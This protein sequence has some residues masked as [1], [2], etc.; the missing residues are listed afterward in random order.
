MRKRL[1][2]GGIPKLTKPGI[3]GD[4]GRGSFGLQLRVH[5][6]KTG[7]TTRSFRQAIRVGG[8]LTNL[9]LGSWP[10][11]SLEGA[12]TRCLEN[13]VAVRRGIDPRTRSKAVRNDP[14]PSVAIP[15]A[16]PVPATVP[17]F[18]A[19]FEKVIDAARPNWKNGGSE[20][21]RRNALDGLPF[22]DARVDAVTSA[23]IV[24]A[25]TPVWTRT[26]TVADWRARVC[27]E[28]LDRAIGDGL[29]TDNPTGA[30]VKA[31]PK[32]KARVQHRKAIPHREAAAAFRRLTGCAN[33][34]RSQRITSLA[35][36]FLTLTAARGGEV[37][38][39]DWGEIDGDTWTIPPARMKA[40]A[41]HRVPLSREALVVLEEAAGITG[42]RSG[43]IFP[44]S[45]GRIVASSTFAKA[46]RRC[47]VDGTPHGM[48]TTFANWAR[49]EGVS[50][51][52][53]DRALA[54]RE[55]GVQAA[56]FRSDLLD[57][58]RSVM[59]AWGAYLDRARR[60]S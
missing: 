12:R 59:E 2:E 19:I 34:T 9:G 32:R 54:H 6:T 14:G 22:A 1:T 45:T 49:E 30:A 11:V 27:R 55:K 57:A 38:G 42:R 36:R 28:V 47:E 24:K 43:L 20:E 53:I 26:P 50:R 16:A 41:E 13:V 52:L 39:A 10:Y 37:A 44:S 17:T 35:I 31:L 7:H 21:R 46:L 58:R 23:E 48:R 29:R 8:R 5:R 3:Y 25:L 15:V 56:Y 60:S 18:R 40:E 51:D 4:G 33:R